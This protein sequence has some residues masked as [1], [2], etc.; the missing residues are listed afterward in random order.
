M[1]YTMTGPLRFNRSQYVFNNAAGRCVW[2]EK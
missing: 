2:T 1:S